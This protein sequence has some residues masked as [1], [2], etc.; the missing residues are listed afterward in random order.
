M[1]TG[2][3]FHFMDN[4]GR[5]SI[6]ARYRELLQERQ[7]RQVILTNFDGYLLAFP[8]SEWV[9]IEGKL[10]DLALFRKDLR[11]FQ[12]FLISGVEECPL[13]RQG[14]VLI[15]QN[16]RDYAKLSREVTLV[17][18][19]RCFEIW[20]RVTYEAHRKQL[21]ESINEEVLHE[22]LI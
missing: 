11:A 6:P 7:D 20:D 17:G 9:K 16:L 18:A 3:F 19:V 22:L 2:S 13:D 1:F 14:R 10:G 12:R 8:Q 21:E 5:V 4:K 15:P